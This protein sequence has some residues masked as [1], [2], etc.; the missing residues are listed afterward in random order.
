MSLHHRNKRPEGTDLQARKK[1]KLDPDL[2]ESNEGSLPGS[3][4]LD[5]HRRNY[6]PGLHAL[7]T[8][9]K[10]KEDS[11]DKPGKEDLGLKLSVWRKRED[12]VARGPKLG[13]GP[14]PDFVHPVDPLAAPIIP[15]EAI[16]E[17]PL[18]DDQQ[19]VLDLVMTGASVFFTGSAGTG[20]SFLLRVIID[21]LRE[22]YPGPGEV[23]VCSTT[24]LSAAKIGGTTVHSWAGLGNVNEDVQKA[25]WSLHKTKMKNQALSRWYFSKVL[26]LDE[27]APVL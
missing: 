21:A 4:A 14:I 22:K 16:P 12:K 10:V 6:S 19:D 2:P 9:V 8:N 15:A 5:T 11:A 17:L 1:P 23:A 18:T 25:Y 13:R 3:E 26:I 20:K 27:G 24:G 7:D